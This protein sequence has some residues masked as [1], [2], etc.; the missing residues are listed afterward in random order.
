M[1]TLKYMY[2]NYYN[3]KENNVVVSIQ[4]T[5]EF[6]FSLKLVITFSAQMGYTLSLWCP[7][8]FASFVLSF[9][10]TQMTFNMLFTGETT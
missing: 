10:A 6:L 5:N 8:Y 1:H 9:A 7:F 4:P 2:Y 3:R